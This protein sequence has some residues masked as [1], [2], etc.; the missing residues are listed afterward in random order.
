MSAMIFRGDLADAVLDSVSVLVADMETGE[1]LWGSEPLETMFGYVVK[2]ELVGCF[3][4]HL[5]PVSL[6]IQ[7]VEHRK[8]YSAKPRVRL[9]RTGKAPLSGQRQDGSTFPVEITLRPRV[10][11]GRRCVVAAVF[12]LTERVAIV[13]VPLPSQE[14]AE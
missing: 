14:S 2:G 9:M 10:V 13:E 11:A 5:V 8:S 6:R 12:D 7:H 4:E 1:I 3:V